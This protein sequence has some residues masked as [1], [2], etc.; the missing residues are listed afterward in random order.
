MPRGGIEL[1]QH[2]SGNYAANGACKNGRIENSP[3]FG[4]LREHVN[5]KCLG[6]RDRPLVVRQPALCRQSRAGSDVLAG[7][8]G[9]LTV[10]LTDRQ[11]ALVWRRALIDLR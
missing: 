6:R 7:R 8:L 5:R 9:Q 3:L 11:A 2:V 10:Q 4:G 1:H